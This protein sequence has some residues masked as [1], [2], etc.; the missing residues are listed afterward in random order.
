MKHFFSKTV[1][2]AVVAT[3]GY[4][5]QPDVLAVLPKKAAA[6]VTGIG[7]VV[8]VVGARGAIAKNGTGQ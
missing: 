4:L 1:L 3:F 2:G 8:S 5:S 7:V 6:I